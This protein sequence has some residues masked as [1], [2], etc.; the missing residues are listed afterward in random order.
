MLSPLPLEAQAL[1]SFPISSA[2]WT[3]PRI[4]MFLS[5]AATLFTVLVSTPLALTL[6]YV[7]NPFLICSVVC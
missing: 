5:G 4:L 7:A 1:C 2:T 6:D 3:N